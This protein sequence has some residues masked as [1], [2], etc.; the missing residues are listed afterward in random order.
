MADANQ[1]NNARYKGRRLAEPK[2][3]D[4]Y[5]AIDEIEATHWP[6]LPIAQSPGD[7]YKLVRF[8]PKFDYQVFASTSP[9]LR[10]MYENYSQFR[11]RSVQVLFESPLCG[12]QRPR[13]EIGIY[14]IP[15]HFQMDEAVDPAP[16]NWIEFGE[17]NHTSIVSNNG[18]HSRFKLQYVP[19]LVKREQLVEDEGPEHADRFIYTNGDFQSGWMNTDENS[20]TWEHRG[21]MVVFRRPYVPVGAG[22][23]VVDTYSVKIRTVWEFRNLKNHA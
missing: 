9:F 18:A 2:L 12:P 21:P 23:D 5:A 4:R 22:E 20:K 10:A 11:C 7:F 19:Q 14:W 3:C 13:I 8:E 15:N 16:T 6:V 1:Y 17:K